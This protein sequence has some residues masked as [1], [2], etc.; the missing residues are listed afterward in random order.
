MDF[1]VEY[2]LRMGPVHAFDQTPAILGIELY[3]TEHGVVG[4]QIILGEL[5]EK[6]PGSGIHP[7]IIQFLRLAE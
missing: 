4:A 6:N 5:F 7:I 2:G 3:R 1:G